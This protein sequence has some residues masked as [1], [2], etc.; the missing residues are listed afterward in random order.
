MTEAVLLGAQVAAVPDSLCRSMKRI[1]LWR[2]LLDI[3]DI[4]TQHYHKMHLKDFYMQYYISFISQI[5]RCLANLALE[6]LEERNLCPCQS[7]N[8]CRSRRHQ[9]AQS[10]F[11]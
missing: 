5:F 4:I 11:H 1:T 2:A 3:I 9:T 8:K 7:V 10:G 6:L